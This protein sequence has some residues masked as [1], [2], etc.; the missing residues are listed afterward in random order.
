MKLVQYAVIAIL[1]VSAAFAL[2][3]WKTTAE[4]QAAMKTRLDQQWEKYAGDD[5][6]KGTGSQEPAYYALYGAS[7]GYDPARIEKAIS[8]IQ[9]FLITDEK[10][11]AY[12][13]CYWY[14][15]DTNVNDYNAIQFTMRI[16]VLLYMHY[17]DRLT[18]KAKKILEDTFKLGIEGVKRQRVRLSYSN[19]ILKKIFNLIALGEAMNMPEVA[20]EGYRIFDEWL[21][22]TYQ[23]GLCEFLSP[24]YYQIDVE[25]LSLIQKYAKRPEARDAAAQALMF[26]WTDILA[27]WYA[28]SERLGGTHSR[29]YDR[30]TGHGGIDKLVAMSGLV[31][32]ND[33]NTTSTPFEYFSFA[34]PSA[35]LASYAKGPFPR[36]MF[37]RWGDKP[38]NWASHY[39]GKNISIASA[40]CNY[41]DMD[42]TPL[43]I[44]IGSGSTTPVINYWM[45]GRG[46]YFGKAKILERSGHMKSLHL[47]PFTMS[48]QNDA[49]VLF[50]SSIASNGSDMTAGVESTI[51]LPA[52]AE[53]WTNEARLD[54][55]TKRSA[56]VHSPGADNS[57][58]FI[59]VGTSD[60]APALTIVDKNDKA[61]V[62]I[63]QMVPVKAGNFYREKLRVKGGIISMYMNWHDKNKVRIEPEYIKEITGGTAYSVQ[64]FVAQAPQGAEYC[65]VW[66]YSRGA[67]TTEVTINDITFEDI[68][69]SAT[70]AS[71]S[72]LAS[73]D[74]VEP[75]MQSFA[76]PA[77][78]DIF[79]RRGDAV[80]ALRMISARTAAG[81]EAPLT[82]YNDGLIHNT[83]RLTA[84]HDPERT[85]KRVAF[86]MYAYAAEGIQSDAAFADVRKKISAVRTRAAYKDNEMTVQSKGITG[87]MKLVGDIAAGERLTMEGM[88]PGTADNILSINGRDAGRE[89]LG[90]VPAVKTYLASPKKKASLFRETA[91]GLFVINPADGTLEK[92][93]QI[94]DGGITVPV[95]ASGNNGSAAYTFDVAADGDYVVW[96]RI[97]AP[98]EKN[99]SAFIQ[100]DDKKKTTYDAFD[101]IKEWAWDTARERD[102][103]K[104]KLD[105]ISVYP[106]RRGPHTLTISE[107]ESG[108]RIGGIIVVKKDLQFDPKKT[109]IPAA[110]SQAAVSLITNGNFTDADGNGMPDG[111]TERFAPNKTTTFIEAVRADGVSAVKITD[112]DDKKGV[113]LMQIVAVKPGETYTLAAKIKS[114]PIYFYINWLD[115]DKK[116][117]KPENSK[118]FKGT[119]AFKRETY[120]ASAPAN[121]AYAQVWFY[122]VTSL[123]TEVFITDASFAASGK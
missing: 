116:D 34:Q 12:G 41:W 92:P 66:I 79:I 86:A 18:P 22:Y 91:P 19:I 37:Q 100:M 15:G 123:K 36:F 75:V 64:E 52:D 76:I 106:L 8:W 73:F 111:W 49:E 21:V 114:G 62:G 26:I 38:E 110:A 50:L 27:N 117:I 1:S 42:K 35:S 11:R 43:V 17:S 89:I 3:P 85:G 46:D 82:L 67:S 118:M 44:N 51:S 101:R 109:P 31:L 71:R 13:N 20:A 77:G 63:Q 93:M 119:G 59:T 94:V 68:G 7:I 47:K 5:L 23:N 25:N 29:D 28:P 105:N 2:E 113:G 88:R 99:D 84:A 121:A 6:K 40:G 108:F 115:A 16:S 9:K 70:G 97:I 78:V 57:T 10:N 90:A 32:P 48:V 14:W 69:T 95:D 74:F 107:R 102:G 104:F 39:L 53:V 83:L 98:T 33:K 80:A 55:F 112:N 103:D 87:D 61:G 65:L 4:A 24:T 96:L 45:D 54:V 30:L 56:W 60:G 81:G 122:S 120:E 72:V 58:T